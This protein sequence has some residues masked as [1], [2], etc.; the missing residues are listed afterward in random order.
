MKKILVIILVMPLL[1][2]MSITVYAASEPT[3]LYIHYYRYDN[4]YTDWNV[5]LW[6]SEPESLEGVSYDFEQ[7]DT[8]TI[9][10]YGGRVAKIS[11]EGDLNGTTKIGIIIRKGDWLEK[12][13]ATD[14]F[15]IIPDETDNGELHTYFVESDPNI[16]YSLDDENG[17]DKSPKFTSAYFTS[18]N[19][20]FYQATETL[21]AED[22]VIYENDMSIDTADI[23]ITEQSGIITLDQDMS[24]EN[25]YTIEAKFQDDTTNTLSITYDGIYDTEA[26]ETAYNYEGDDLGAI[27]NN[28]KTSFMLWAPISENVTLN[29]YDTGTPAIYGGTDTP[30]QT[31]PMQKDVNGTYYLEIN[32]SLH[33]YYYTYSVT[34]TGTTNEVVDPYAKSTGING[35]RG[36]VVDFSQTNPQGFSYASRANNMTNYNDAIIYELHVR[37]LTSHSSWTG[38]EENRSKYL[39]LIESGTTYN[40]VTTGFDHIVELGVTHVQLLPFF[41]YG[42][43]DETKLD[44]LTYNA[45]NWGYMPLNFNSLEGTYSSDPYDGLVR[46]N[47]MKQ[48]TTAFTEANIRVNM[49]VVYNHTGLSADSNFD[50][51]VPG[52]YYRMTENGSFSN[53]SGTGNETASERSMMSK[54]M[55]DSVLFWANEYNISGFRFD[56]MALHDI[57]TME[58]LT[59]KLHEIDPT[60]MVYGEPW[61]GGTTTLASDFQANKTNLS[62]IEGVAAF[63]DDIRDGIK[64]SVFI[65]EMGGYIQGDFSSQNESKVKYGV[66]GGI[67]FDSISES[68]LSANK[69]WHTSP[70]K[71][72]NYVTAHDNNTLYDK[73]YQ[74]VEDPENNQELIASLAKQANAIVLTSQGIPFLHTGDEI[75]RSKPSADGSG[76]DHNSYESPDSVN[77]IRWDLK[78]NDLEMSVFEY[79]KDIIAFRKNHGSLSM[80]TSQEITDN[81]SFV[82]DE[83]GVIAYT[84]KNTSSNDTYENMLVI[85]NA[86]SKT[87][88]LKLPKNGGWVLVGNE[89]TVGDESIETYL[90]GSKIKVSANSSYILYQDTSIEDINRTPL[91][92]G[93]SIGAL[94]ILAGGTYLF[95]HKKTK[96]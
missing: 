15:I 29:L 77:Q 85:H 9:F 80:D 25:A 56:L 34:N 37:D 66:V 20:I 60:I 39:G 26:F 83:K 89:N 5:W 19:T 14:R 93:L 53:G 96:K 52:Y 12:D 79:Y 88:K 61:M 90:G 2:L 84:I 73:L 70:Q 54:F 6:A 11:L 7:D 4:D 18:L 95:I 13:V 57:E 28:N 8:D 65:G 38:T 23:Q 44:D 69:A 47:E 68:L 78:T 32:Q 46:I 3:N 1:M 67:T 76:F 17:P 58:T 45:F 86:N 33:G 10:N 31:Y 72:L 74:T 75:L 94:L 82:F 62:E 40:G 50:L 63:N 41:D 21:A 71:T 36:L 81:L 22:L 55:V 16:G 42:V 87:V 64:G 35:L 30:T 48:V 43:V 59:E 27:V 51:I 49:D 92:I 91:I 24:F